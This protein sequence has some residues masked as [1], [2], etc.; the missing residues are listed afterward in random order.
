MPLALV[1]CIDF[2]FYVI[3]EL[4]DLC[5]AFQL[6]ACDALHSLNPFL[7]AFPVIQRAHFHASF[8]E[9]VEMR[10]VAESAV[11]GNF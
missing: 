8:E 1:R 2:G 7:K 3:C 10:N 9:F 4:N 11:E 6:F 5:N